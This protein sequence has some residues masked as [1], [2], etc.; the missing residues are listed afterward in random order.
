MP[1]T[2]RAAGAFVFGLPVL[3]ACSTGTDLET[4]SD[5]VVRAAVA[6][7][8][9]AVTVEASAPGWTGIYD[10]DEEVT[11]LRLT[12]E[13]GSARPI[14]LRYENL[15][16]VTG[17]GRTFSALPL[18]QIEGEVQEPVVYRG[19]PIADP[20]FVGEG[21]LP[22]PY[23]RGVYPGYPVYSGPF[24]YNWGFGNAY[25][26]YYADIPLPTD[27]MQ[28]LA[29]PEGV[30]EPGGRVEGWIYFE[31]LPDEVRQAQLRVDLDDARTGRT[32]NEVRVPFVNEG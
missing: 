16:L 2:L 10:I 11:P 5:G 30:L 31:R 14:A 22:A 27:R 28:T 1:S 9:G 23:Y 7:S 32:L 13:N 3:A 6:P 25:R 12:I 19:N 24:A 17:D 21:Y 15:D 20:G 29:L 8:T 26:T 18:Y 4:T